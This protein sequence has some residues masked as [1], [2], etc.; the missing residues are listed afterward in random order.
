MLN[1]LCTI[2]LNYLESST[3]VAPL[4]PARAQP[5]NWEQ[6][7]GSREGLSPHEASTTSKGE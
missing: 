4:L 3:D 5:Q 2:S 1:D 6:F 7:L